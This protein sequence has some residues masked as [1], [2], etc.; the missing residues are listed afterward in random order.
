MKF[1]MAIAAVCFALV[2]GSVQASANEAVSSSTFNAGVALETGYV[3]TQGRRGGGFRAGGGGRGFVR[4]GG[5][6]NFGRNV[7]IGLGA[8]VIG[9]II[10]NEAYRSRPAGG[11]CRS[12]SYQCSN[13]SG[14]ACRQ[15]DRY[16]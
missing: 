7:G 2:C 12:W 10:A 6:R 9:G 15:M 11:N 4:G 5:R 13:G 14:W 1:G 3:T 8:A 16:C